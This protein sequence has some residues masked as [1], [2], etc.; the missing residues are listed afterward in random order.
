MK[1]LRQALAIN[2]AFIFGT[3]LLFPAIVFLAAHALFPEQANGSLVYDSQGRLIGSAIIGQ[4]FSQAK[5]FHPRPSAAGAGY[6]AANSSGTNLGP[7]SSKL[8]DGKPDDPS[9]PDADESYAGLKGLA[10]A[11]RKENG[12]TGDAIIPADAVTHSA[13]GLDPDISPANARLQAGRI[14]AARGIEKAAV[15]K[16]VERSIK[17]RYLGIFGEPRANVLELNLALDRSN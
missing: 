4:Q 2:G 5:Y 13:S 6:D 1:M 16:L 7:I 11:Y 9:T 17:A 14:A 3:G 12:L 8:I 15:E 10:A